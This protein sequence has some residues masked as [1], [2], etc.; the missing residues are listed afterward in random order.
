MPISSSARAPRWTTRGSSRRCATCSGSTGEDRA[1][2]MTLVTETPSSVLAVYA[3]PDDP[4][5]SAGGTLARWAAAGASVSLLITTRGEKGTP[6][7]R[8][9]PRRA[10]PRCGSR[11]RRRRPSCSA[12]PTTSTSTGATARS[13]TTLALRGA[14]V[15]VRALRASRRRAV[16]RS[17]RRLLRLELLQPPRPPRDGLGDARRRRARGRQSRTTSPS[18]SARASRSTRSAP[19]TC[20]GRSS[21]TA[22]STSAR[23]SSARSTRCSVTQASSPRPA[24]GSASSCVRAPKKPGA[25][26][27]CR[28]AEAFRRIDLGI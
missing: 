6:R 10:R 11:R 13:R 4:E 2:R 27:A 21:R 25:P 19:S 1:A 3:H 15:P 20:R 16:P 14:I 12:W 28:Y 18:T 23:P 17:D 7:P 24:T 5:I 9:R 8:R 22:G 26:P